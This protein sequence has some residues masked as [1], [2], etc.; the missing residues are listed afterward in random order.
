MAHR[1]GPGGM[2]LEMGNLEK[3]QSEKNEDNED[4]SKG[5]E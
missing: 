2:P 1:L 3:R 5:E 4:G